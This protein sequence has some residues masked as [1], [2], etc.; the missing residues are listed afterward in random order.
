MI[1][2]TTSVPVAEGP[3]DP[4]RLATRTGA[5]LGGCFPITML[6]VVAWRVRGP[7]TGFEALVF[8]GF[9]F[10]SLLFAPVA[11]GLG[12]VGARLALR[13]TLD[14]RAASARLYSGI[15]AAVLLLYF[16]CIAPAEALLLPEQI[17]FL[18]TFFAH[19]LFASCKSALRVVNSRA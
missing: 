9:G 5:I 14:R 16:L 1:N 7:T 12:A 17:I 6:A 2:A 11:A 3:D 15:V 19:V 8:L 10:Y 4:F 18:G 13:L